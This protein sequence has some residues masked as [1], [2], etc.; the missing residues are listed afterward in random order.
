MQPPAGS[1]CG[2]YLQAYAQAAGG[3]IYNPGATA[4]CQYCPLVNTDQSLAATN[5][6]YSE[7][8]RNYGIG[9]AYIIFNIFA[10]VL[11]Y[12][13]IRVRK[14]SGKGLGEKLAPVLKLF[15]KDPEAEN[16]GTEKKKEA[17]Q[18]KGGSISP[19]YNHTT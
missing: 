5:V 4:D 19:S 12:Y 16:K 15:K 2:T 17:P 18:A 9:F 8:W 1:T 7:R 10:A 13:L 3:A 11:F 14:G 6:Y